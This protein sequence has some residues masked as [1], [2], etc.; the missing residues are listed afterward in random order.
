M[1]VPRAVTP[2]GQAKTPSPISV[3]SLGAGKVSLCQRTQGAKRHPG[4]TPEA[5]TGR[6]VTKEAWA[7]WPRLTPRARGV[8]RRPGTALPPAQLSG[9]SLGA[10]DGSA[11]RPAC[12][13]CAQGARA[14]EAAPGRG[15]RCPPHGGP[16]RPGRPPSVRCCYA[17]NCPRGRRSW[18]K[19]SVSCLGTFPQKV[20]DEA[21]EGAATT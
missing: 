3:V 21:P 14:R 8:P 10:T 5:P 1:T 7:L 16:P 17:G 13:P 15:S 2:C 18:G 4:E 12:W 9:P 19:R 11:G 20:G 6:S